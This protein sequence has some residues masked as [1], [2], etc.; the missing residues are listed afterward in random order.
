MFARWV[1]GSIALCCGVSIDLIVYITM[2]CV[3]GD[4]FAVTRDE[5]LVT[6]NERYAM[7][8]DL[9]SSG[10]LFTAGKCR[11]PRVTRQMLA[12]MAI[13]DSRMV[14]DLTGKESTSFALRANV[15]IETTVCYIVIP[16]KEP[17]TLRALLVKRIA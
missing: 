15:K 11:L 8:Q 5:K 7:T 4:C 2:I 12:E 9:N 6:R 1:T 16:S 17:E 3:H 10:G 13:G 14:S